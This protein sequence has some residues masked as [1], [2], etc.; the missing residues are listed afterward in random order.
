MTKAQVR[1]KSKTITFVYMHIGAKHMLELA[2]ESRE[3]QLYTAMSA[4][5]YCAFTLEAYVN[6]LGAA[7]HADWETME[8]KK[9]AKDK[10]KGLAKDVG[11]KVDFGKSP[12]STMRALFAFRDTIAHG[13][14]T[15]EKVDKFIDAEGP[16]LP[17]IAGNTG[18]QTYATIEN[19]RQAIKDVETMV[20]ALHKSSGFTGNPFASSGGGFYG[21]KRL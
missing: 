18:W 14:T 3:G 6:H 7:R 17:Q 12:F 2:E 20:K 11:V 9:S 16:Y 19:A 13:R 10:L 15:H 5:I 1:G 21:V 8:K 4:L